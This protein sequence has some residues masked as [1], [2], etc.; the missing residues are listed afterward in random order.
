VGFEVRARV[1]SKA[2]TLPPTPERPMASRR[3]GRP[4]CRR[5]D[6]PVARRRSRGRGSRHAGS[7]PPRQARGTPG[8]AQAAQETGIR[9]EIADD[10]QA[11]LLRVRVSAASP[12][13][14]GRTIAPRILTK[15]CDGESGKCRY[16]SR[17][18]LPSAFSIC[19]LPSI[20]ISTYQRHLVSRSTLRIFRAEA[21]AQWQQDRAHRRSAFAINCNPSKP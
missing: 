9:A 18:A 17:P 13:G 16:S 2:S 3:N 4:D 10:R 7:A 8:D 6:V 20:T 5:A 11:G 12:E 19:T 14:C 1:C 15:S 21:A